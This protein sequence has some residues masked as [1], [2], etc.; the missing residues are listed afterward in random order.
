MKYFSLTTCL[1]F[2]TNPLIAADQVELIQGKHSIKAMIGGDVFTVFQYSKD[3]KKPFFLP[4]TGPDGYGLLQHATPGEEGEAGRKVIVSSE[5]AAVSAKDGGSTEVKLNE[6]LDVE[7]IEG[8]QLW[9]KEPAGWIHRSDVA[10]LAATVTRIINDNPPKVKDRKSPLYYDHPHHKGVWLSV[11]EVN[12]IKFWNEDGRIE[13]VSVDVVESKGNPAV[14][15]RVNH[16]LDADGEPLVK[17]ETTIALYPNRLM[18]ADIT[19]AAV[20]KTVTFDDTK[21]GMFA[22]RLPNSMREMVAGGPVKNADGDEGTSACWGKA[23]RWV[24]YCGPIDGHVFGVTLMDHPNNPRPSR[25]HVRNYGLFGI[26]PF[27]V[28]AYTKGKDYE[29]PAEPLKLDKGESIRLRY[30]L[31]VHDGEVADSVIESAFKQFAK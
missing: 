6:I 8:D 22:I 19:Y 1:L 21:E 23:S 5:G 20:D 7:R 16:W 9:V 17:E 18:T 3:R 13:N 14:M 24:D 25:Y 15:K 27:G 12:G 29:Q 11:D 26:N 10:P 31:F 4:V 28:H 30:G 2:L